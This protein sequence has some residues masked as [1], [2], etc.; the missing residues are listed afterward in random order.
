MV[1]WGGKLCWAQLAGS[2]LSLAWPGHC[3][4]CS[5]LVGWLGTDWLRM[6]SLRNLV[7]GSLSGGTREIRIYV[8]YHPARLSVI[9]M[10][11][12][13]WGWGG[14]GFKGARETHQVSWGL[15]FTSATFYWLIQHK[16][17]PYSRGRCGGEILA[18]SKKNYKTALQRAWYAL[19]QEKNCGHFDD[20]IGHILHPK[21]LTVQIFLWVLVT[22]L[23]FCSLSLGVLMVHAVISRLL[24]RLCSCLPKGTTSLNFP[25]IQL[26]FVFSS[27]PRPSLNYWSFSIKPGKLNICLYLWKSHLEGKKALNP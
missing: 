23:Y 13:G 18:F 16:I 26:E 25:V 5:Q 10:E 9:L 12:G 1:L 11:A 20:V 22:S 6:A 21:A 8:S 7:V 24:S 4:I 27:L 19:A 3:G 17:N 2:G 15:I 14:G